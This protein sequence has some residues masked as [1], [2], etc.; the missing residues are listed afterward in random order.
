MKK[1]FVSAVPLTWEAASEAY[2]PCTCTPASRAGNS[3]G[4]S[5]LDEREGIPDVREAVAQMTNV[6]RRGF[7]ALAATAPIAPA[8]W[9]TAATA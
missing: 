2:A 8:P 4:A 9:V 5:F 1:G 7:L 6:S 3:T